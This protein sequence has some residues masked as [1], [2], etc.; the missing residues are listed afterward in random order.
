MERNEVNE[1]FTFWYLHIDNDFNQIFR[2]QLTKY[3]WVDAAMNRMNAWDSTVGL[4]ETLFTFIRLTQ[5]KLKM[6]VWK[7]I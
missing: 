3:Y 6:E 7:T 2:L 5:I 1:L 4:W